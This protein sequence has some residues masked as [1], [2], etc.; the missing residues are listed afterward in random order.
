MNNV[1]NIIVNFFNQE[2]EI[3][4]MYFIFTCSTHRWI[5]LLSFGLLYP[6]KGVLYVCSFYLAVKTRKIKIK[7]LNGAKYIAASVYS[8]SII[9]AMTI[10]ASIVLTN[11]INAYAAV[12]S[13]GFWLLN[14][15]ML[16]LL[17]IPKVSMQAIMMCTIGLSPQLII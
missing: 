10:I 17:F 5:R 3:E 4:T 15:L 9:L 1:V 13:F 12:Y 6:Y 8:T 11:Y 7:G 2:Q 16:G 14:S